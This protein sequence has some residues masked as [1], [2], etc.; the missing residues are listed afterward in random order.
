MELI[1]ESHDLLFL[2]LYYIVLRVLKGLTGKFENCT[3]RFE[4]L[5]VLKNIYRASKLRARYL[6][7][8]IQTFQT[9]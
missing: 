8:A 1:E 3:Q 6:G 2:D 7:C 5:L 9:D 4:N